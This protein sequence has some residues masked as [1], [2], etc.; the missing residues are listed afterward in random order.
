MT[1][2]IKVQDG[3][4]V[5]TASDPE[6]SLDFS[7]DG[8]VNV[9]KTVNVG[10]DPQSNGI[11]TS[12]ESNLL[13]TSKNHNVRISSNSGRVLINNIAWPMYN[14]SAHP[15]TFLGVESLNNLHFYPFVLGS[16][17]NDTLVSADLN[18]LFP[19]AYPGQYVAGP[20]VAYLCIALNTWR[21]LGGSST[22]S[23][24]NMAYMFYQTPDSNTTL[25]GAL[26][27]NW[28]VYYQSPPHS[29]TNDVTWD[30]VNKHFDI[31][32]AGTYSLTIF[33]KVNMSSGTW[34]VDA[35]L[36][37]SEIS[38]TAYVIEPRSINQ[39]SENDTTFATWTDVFTLTAQP[40]DTV[41]VSAY[42][43]NVAA[44]L[45]TVFLTC[46]ATFTNIGP[47]FSAMQ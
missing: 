42:A 31:N 19:D 3:K 27:N 36:Y 40:G 33:G 6:Y 16:V 38:G 8:Q 43:E 1:Q 23:S 20:T 47:A 28:N 45:S 22:Q 26:Y 39:K 41:S 15:G 34:P 17:T 10:F 44:S 18:L 2:K 21:R 46:T 14:N 7:V 35:T 25:E 29:I 30:S 24:G 11:I 37:G 32:V 13:V 12:D 9:T 5:Y 4:I